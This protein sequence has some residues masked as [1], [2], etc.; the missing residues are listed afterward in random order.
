MYCCHQFTK[1][2]KRRERASE[3]KITKF[4][5]YFLFDSHT[6]NNNRHIR[7][8]KNMRSCYLRKIL[9]FYSSK[10]NLCIQRDIIHQCS[11][12]P[13]PKC[14][15]IRS[16]WLHVRIW[17]Q[18]RLRLRIGQLFQQ[19]FSIFLSAWALKPWTKL[20]VFGRQSFGFLLRNLGLWVET[21]ILFWDFPNESADTQFSSIEIIVYDRKMSSANRLCQCYLI[22]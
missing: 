16:N 9:F 15:E 3:N 13:I 5:V 21:M 10:I 1:K 17:T 18:I 19:K 14:F 22:I 6:Y 20:Y 2:E 4:Y 11:R 7:F 12:R 8:D